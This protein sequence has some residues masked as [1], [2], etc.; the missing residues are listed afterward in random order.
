MS[1]RLLIIGRI[2]LR[3]W[4][5]PKVESK[6]VAVV[7]L[8]YCC[9]TFMPSEGSPTD[10]N[11]QIQK[12]KAGSDVCLS[13][14]GRELERI[15]FGRSPAGVPADGDKPLQVRCYQNQECCIVRVD[16]RLHSILRA[17]CFEPR[18]DNTHAFFGS[19]EVR[20]WRQYRNV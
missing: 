7:Y 8:R 11:G 4:L 2:V 1:H 3:F 5:G 14:C 10:R 20:L 9:L 13:I 17:I 15:R 6:A 18:C 19:R 12:T 16:R